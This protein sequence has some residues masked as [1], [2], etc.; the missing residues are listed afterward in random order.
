M[1]SK[2]LV[3]WIVFLGFTAFTVAVFA[4]WGLLG[5]LQAGLANGPTIQVG[6]DLVIMVVLF[7]FWLVPDARQRGLSP[8]P[9]VALCCTLGSIGALF[10]LIVRERRPVPV[11]A[12]APA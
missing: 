6:L 7:L 4:Q 9:F 5:F 11:Q 10:Y 1:Q 3:V 8:W 12:G 2:S